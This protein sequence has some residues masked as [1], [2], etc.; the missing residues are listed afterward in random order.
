MPLTPHVKNSITSVA[1]PAE[2][3]KLKKSKKIEISLAIPG[4]WPVYQGVSKL[5]DSKREKYIVPAKHIL[6]AATTPKPAPPMNETKPLD[7]AFIDAAPF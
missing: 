4:I 1:A 5:V 7:L 3:Q 2:P 6:K